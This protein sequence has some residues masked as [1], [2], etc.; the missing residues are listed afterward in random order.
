M[1]PFEAS[2]YKITNEEFFE[3]V[4][5]NG[6][7]NPAYWTEEG[8]KW[9]QYKQAK[10]PPFWVSPNNQ[11]SGCG[12]AIKA[13]SHCQESH[14]TESELNFIRNGVHDGFTK[15]TFRLDFPYK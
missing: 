4:K 8:W 2:K 15:E 7:E 12:G 13:Y 3:F 6:Y 14:F 1:T 11:V 9:C 10:H 5:A